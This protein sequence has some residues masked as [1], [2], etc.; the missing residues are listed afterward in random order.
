[1]IPF[2]KNGVSKNKNLTEHIHVLIE[3]KG[4]IYPGIDI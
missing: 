4:I 3:L 2:I 1:M